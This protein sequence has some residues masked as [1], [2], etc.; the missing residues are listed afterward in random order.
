M[1]Y[2]QLYYYAVRGM[3][4]S[5]ESI[6]LKDRYAV[7]ATELVATEMTAQEFMEDKQLWTTKVAYWLMDAIEFDEAEYNKRKNKKD[8]I[9]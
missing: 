1:R 7:L 3:K 9:L 2:F 5:G 6:P 4:E 8:Y